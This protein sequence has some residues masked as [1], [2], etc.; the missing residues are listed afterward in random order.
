[1]GRK[2]FPFRL[3]P[4]SEALVMQ[5]ARKSSKQIR[6]LVNIGGKSVVLFTCVSYPYKYLLELPK[7]QNVFKS[8]LVGPFC[9]KAFTLVQII[10]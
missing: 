1:M 9:L 4:F 3:E 10:F 8:L 5:K 6:F 2:F 7:H